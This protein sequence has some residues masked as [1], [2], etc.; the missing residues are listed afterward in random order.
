MKAV[1]NDVKHKLSAEREMCDPKSI[2]VL[3]KQLTLDEVP[4]KAIACPF[5]PDA[6]KTRDPTSCIPIGVIRTKAPQ[7]K[8]MACSNQWGLYE[9]P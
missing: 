1:V 8:R 4:A 6:V 3:R 5:V 2:V 7:F 9:C